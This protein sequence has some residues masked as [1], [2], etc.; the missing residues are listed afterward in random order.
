MKEGDREDLDLIIRE[1]T[2]VREIVRGLLDF[3]RE[4]PSSKEPLIVNEVIENTTKLIRSQKEYRLISIEENLDLHL[5]LM[6]GDKNQLQQVILNLVLNACEAMPDGGILQ[7]ETSSDEETVQVVIKDNGCGIKRE[8]QEKIF[9][10]FFT[11]K[12][13]GKGTGLGLSVTYGIIQSH[14]GSID[15]ESEENQG[16]TF[17]I[18]FPA[19][20]TNNENEVN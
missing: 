3:A 16:T 11:T 9:D 15:I 14:N 19:L 1:T 4:S 6:M 8:D 20:A 5:P 2:R 13:L 18:S 7:L 10:P 12:P 17:V